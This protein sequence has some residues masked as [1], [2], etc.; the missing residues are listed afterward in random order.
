MKQLPIIN[1][2]SGLHKNNRVLFLKFAFNKQLIKQMKL[3][4][5]D[6]SQ[7]QKVWH[8]PNNKENLNLLFERFRGVAWLNL[9]AL[10]AA[11]NISEAFVNQKKMINR[12]PTPQ[13]YLLFLKRKRYSLNTIKTYC[14]FLREF[15]GFMV[16]KS[17]EDCKADDIR[18]YINYLVVEK[19]VA[20]STQNQAINAL[21][22]YYENMLGWDRFSIKIERPRKEKVLPK[23]LSEQEVLRM[24]K[25]TDNLK[26]KLIICLLYS[27]GIRKG[28]LLHLR[29]EDLFFDKNIIFV[30]GGKGKK[31]RTTILSENLKKLLLL[32]LK[33]YKPNY[34]LIENNKR[35][36]YSSTS[37]GKIIKAAAK[38]VGIERNI[39]AHMFRHSFATHLLE[40]GLGLRYIQQLLGHSSSKT[41][42]IYTHVSNKSLAKI[43]SPLDTLLES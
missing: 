4:Q 33:E 40:Q 19:K 34:W 1:V 6:W 41:T 28:E 8:I 3:I 12:I 23:I 37:V 38:K 35:S 9:K 26:H 43:K 24:I 15:G 17:L 31:D 29:K 27:S 14:S 7:T 5:A 39:T 21:K 42:E 13:E 22:C 10:K 2:S 11:K 25:I 18:K 32:Y 36:Q 30:R 20:T 16:P